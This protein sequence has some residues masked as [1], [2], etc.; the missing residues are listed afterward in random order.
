MTIGQALGMS[1]DS[2]QSV[3]VLSEFDP[4]VLPVAMAF[5]VIILAALWHGLTR[6]VGLVVGKFI[7]DLRFD[8]ALGN[9]VNAGL[10]FGA[11]YVPAASAVLVAMRLGTAY[12]SVSWIV[13]L[14]AS[15]A[16]GIVFLVYFVFAF[17][18]LHRVPP[19]RYFF[20]L[21]FTGTGIYYLI[22]FV[23]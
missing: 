17:S 12:T 1:E 10:A 15:M 22:N 18:A 2:S 20:L 13:Y 8:G 19:V 3:T 14:L 9:S 7:P 21:C 5:S 16:L 6:L 11:F 23:S 4:K